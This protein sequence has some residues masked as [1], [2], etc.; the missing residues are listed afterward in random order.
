M[1][2]A[3]SL[4]FYLSTGTTA[5]VTVSTIETIASTAS[6]TTSTNGAL[7][8][9]GGVG[10]GGSLNVGGSITVGG[11]TYTANNLAPATYQTY[12]NGT[13]S[14]FTLP[15]TPVGASG[16][17]A[18]IDGLVEY[19]YSVT[20]N[21]LTFGFVPANNSI[22]RLFSVG[23]PN[24]VSTSTVGPG[25]VT[26]SSFAANAVQQNLGY[27][28]ANKAGDSLTGSF[29]LNGW[30]ISTA[31]AVSIATAYQYT[32]GTTTTSVLSPAGVWAAAAPV[33]LV[34]A[35][36]ITID[37]ST[38]INFTCTLTAA[39]GATRTLAN[40]VNAKPG[41]TGWIQITQ[42]STGSNLV[43]FGNQWHFSTGT[44]T[45]L[46][47][48]ANVSDLIYYT[49]ISSTYFQTNIAKYWI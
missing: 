37:F 3:E 34:D 4:S 15:F 6:S 18:T 13:T 49:A 35:S 29:T 23:V 48:A 20:A 33:G 17:I 43:T 39:V 16:I 22:I 26:S 24:L 28:P 31:T 30:T 36:T 19:D 21:L 47:T 42:S 27:V 40:P 32:S 41:Q 7:I 14:S 44:V 38:G 46:S 1:S 2:I 10:V 5:S 9:N 25:T 45:A 8:V 12:A 11:V